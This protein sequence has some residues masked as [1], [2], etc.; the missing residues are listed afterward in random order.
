[1]T[2]TADTPTT[3]SVTAEPLVDLDVVDA[4]LRAALDAGGEWAELFAEDRSSTGVLFDEERVEEMNSGRDRGVGMR[5][6]A[7][8]ITGYAHTSD[9]TPEG[10]ADAARTAAAVATRSPVGGTV[11]MASFRGDGVAQPRV[12][13]LPAAI[14]TEHKVALLRAADDAARSTHEAIT[15]VTARYGDSGGGSWWPTP[16][17]SVRRTIRCARCSR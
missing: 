7:G 16:T 4:T 14:G 15:Q 5:V 10:L 13:V 17:A 11:D 1:M 3:V 9:L 2:Q 8:D 6:T 12:E